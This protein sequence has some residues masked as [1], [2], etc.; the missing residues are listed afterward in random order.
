MLVSEIF[1]HFVILALVSLTKKIFSNYNVQVVEKN[2]K[3]NH[4]FFCL[5]PKIMHDLPLPHCPHSLPHASCFSNRK[6]LLNH[7][8]SLPPNPQ[9]LEAVHTHTHTHS[10]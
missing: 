9:Y 4:T 7:S 3:E 10:S 2:I 5:S 8:L 6:M 1:L